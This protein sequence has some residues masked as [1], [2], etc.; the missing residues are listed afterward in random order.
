M[1]SRLAQRRG[2]PIHS[3]TFTLQARHRAPTKSPIRS[4]KALHRTWLF[5]LA[6]Q[7]LARP[8]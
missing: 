4:T 6:K 2:M 3:L 1:R 5:Q 7:S 8:F